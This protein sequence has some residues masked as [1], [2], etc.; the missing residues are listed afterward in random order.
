LALDETIAV[1]AAKGVDV[2]D[3]RA[4]TFK[5]FETAAADLKPS[6]QVDFEQG[7]RLEN[8]WFSGTVVRLGRELAVP[9]PVNQT[10]WACLRPSAGGV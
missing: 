3:F 8:D 10:I 2:T 7:R 9:T 5:F 1:A 4:N 6:L